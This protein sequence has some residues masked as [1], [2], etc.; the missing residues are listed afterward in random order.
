MNNMFTGCSKLRKFPDISKWNV[1]SVT[2]MN[3]MLYGCSLISNL[4]DISKWNKKNVVN[5]CQMVLNCSGLN[6]LPELDKWN[7]SNLKKY[8]L[9]FSNY[10]TTLNY[11][12]FTKKN[13][14][15]SGHNNSTNSIIKPKSEL[16]SNINNIKKPANINNNDINKKFLN[17]CY[18]KNFLFCYKCKN[19]PNN[20]SKN[21]IIFSHLKQD[22]FLKGR[23]IIKILNL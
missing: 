10:K 2:N 8:S 17:P 20:Y 5:M 22:E 12:V 18:S 15:Q 13:V 6:M 4:P 21:K 16:F 14:P 1:C 11:P 3:S 19:I 7:T 9:M 23:I